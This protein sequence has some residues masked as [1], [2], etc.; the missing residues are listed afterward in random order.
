MSREVK[1]CLD[2]GNSSDSGSSCPLLEDSEGE[3]VHDPIPAEDFEEVEEEEDL[4]T[5]RRRIVAGWSW[6]GDFGSAR[7]KDF[8]GAASTT[9]SHE[10][11]ECLLYQAKSN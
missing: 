6:E 8:L 1:Q 2:D 11:V 3:A 9:V 5:F 4:D 10:G 7:P